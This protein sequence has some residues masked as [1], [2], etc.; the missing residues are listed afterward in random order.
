MWIDYLIRTCAFWNSGGRTF[1]VASSFWDWEIKLSSCEVKIYRSSLQTFLFQ[2]FPSSPVANSLHSR[3]KD[4]PQL[5]QSCSV[6]FEV[7]FFISRVS[8]NFDPF[9]LASF[10]RANRRNEGICFNSW[11]SY[12][13]AANAK[14]AL[15]FSPKFELL[16]I[17]FKSELSPLGSSKVAINL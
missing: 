12:S 10:N 16:L 6:S 17:L 7:A 15:Q 2:T 8:C 9:W 1:S 13:Y 3:S 5:I 4:S 14:E 11:S